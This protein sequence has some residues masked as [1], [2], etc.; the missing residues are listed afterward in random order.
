MEEKINTAVPEY[1]AYPK[2]FTPYKWFKPLLVCLLAFVFLSVF[3]SLVILIGSVLG[4]AQGYNIMEMLTGGYNSLDAY[5]L[6]GALIAFGNIVVFLPS[7]LLANR[8]VNAR[9]FSSYSSSRGGF[10]FADFFKSLGAALVLVALPL[11]IYS[12]LT[13]PTRGDVR[14]TA[15]GI[16]LCAVLCPLQCI[17]EEYMFRGLIMQTFGSWIKI[18][19]IPVIL[20]TVCFAMMHPYNFWGIVS[21]AAMGAILGCCT[22]LTKGLEAGSALHIANNMTVFFLSGFGVSSV[23]TEVPFMDALFPIIFCLL[24]LGF[25]IFAD[26]KLGWFSK[27]KKDDVALFNAKI[28]AK[29]A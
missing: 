26:R 17:A 14:F 3:S 2:L 29:K 1:T 25:I 16:I 18:P 11:I 22:C 10:S 5:S 27:V 7:L 12:Y 8:I 9:P 20:Q 15:A 28:Q 24:Y 21:V 13:T 4:A 6:V 19:V 23:A